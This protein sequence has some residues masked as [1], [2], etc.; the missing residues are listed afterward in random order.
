MSDFLMPSLGPDMESARVI[1]WLVK[2]GD[3]LHRGD[4]IVVVET[5]KGAI[6]I[7]VFEDA[8][9]EALIAPLDAE[10]VVGAVMARLRVAG[11]SGTDARAVAATE[12]VEPTVSS[13]APAVAP[14]PPSAVI[15][16]DSV[17]TPA[18][19]SAVASAGHRR[20]SPAARKR[21]AGLGVDLAGVSGS[22]PGGAVLLADLAAVSAPRVKRAGGFDAAAMR[23]VIGAAMARSKREIPHYYLGQKIS[24]AS[25]LRWLRQANESRTV[26]ARL[27]PAV[28]LL[29][30][31]GLA[32]RRTPTL[33][34]FYENGAFRAGD[35][36]HIGWAVA[37][38]GG[39]LVAPAIHDVDKKSLDELM[40]GLRDVVMR[41]RGG[42]LRGSELVDATVTVTSLGERGADTVLP[43]IHP[44]Q[45]A[46]IGFG[47]VVERPWAVAGQVEV[48]PVIG[49]SLAADHRVSD[50]HLGSQLLA[51]I[52]RLLNAPETL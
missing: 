42:A 9:V 33:N 47:R 15:A 31:V 34:G 29:R 46:M 45:V 48:Q 4:V 13:P 12:R 7:E 26:E 6:E 35:G 39:G 36:I 22:G 50:G 27:L 3:T 5:D 17:G 41:A 20:A 28:L 1:E 44:P 11:E 16:Q 24:M 2:P 32:L 43:I 40:T 25:A 23:R 38:R 30:A 14:A 18:A 19:S 49:V 21:A 51:D 8:V 52:E 10:L 37:L